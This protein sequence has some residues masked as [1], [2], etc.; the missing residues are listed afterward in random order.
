MLGRVRNQLFA[1]YF[2]HF[3]VWCLSCRTPAIRTFRF[4]CVFRACCHIVL[5]RIRQV[6]VVMKVFHV[7]FKHVLLVELEIAFGATNVLL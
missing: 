5:V 7:V 3:S 1:S 2:V 4:V 6:R